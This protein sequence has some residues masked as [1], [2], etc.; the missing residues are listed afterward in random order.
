MVL[1]GDSATFAANGS[2]YRKLPYDAQKDFAPI[3]LVVRAAVVLLVNT[4]VILLI[5]YLVMGGSGMMAIAM[6]RVFSGTVVTTALVEVSI[7]E[8]LSPPVA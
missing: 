1:L 2:I 8:I 3:R 6:P 4:N 7:T 5:S